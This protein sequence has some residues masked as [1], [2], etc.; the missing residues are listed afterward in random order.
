MRLAPQARATFAPSRREVRG[1]PHRGGVSKLP[2][3]TAPSTI[4]R[5]AF[6]RA[7]AKLRLTCGK[8]NLDPDERRDVGFPASREELQWVR[9]TV[10]ATVAASTSMASARA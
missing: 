4:L 2:L 3:L 9:R 10:R 8:V 5:W 1:A 6:R 7:G